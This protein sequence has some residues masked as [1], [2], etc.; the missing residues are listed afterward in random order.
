MSFAWN[1]NVDIDH[2]VFEQSLE[3]SGHF[4]S[5]GD[6]LPELFV[7][8]T[9]NIKNDM[10]KKVNSTKKALPRDSRDGQKSPTPAS[11]EPGPPDASMGQVKM[12]EG[13][14]EGVGE[15][16]EP[17]ISLKRNTVLKQQRSVLVRPSYEQGKL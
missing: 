9:R 13:E 8:E 14:G 1:D 17:Y 5:S 10:P 7:Q 12:S 6:D 11:A 16:T 2:K 4:F 15:G 3:N